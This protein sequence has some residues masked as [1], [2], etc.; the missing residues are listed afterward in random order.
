MILARSR[1]SGAGRRLGPNSR[2]G[3][4]TGRR[5]NGGDPVHVHVHVNV[6][7]NVDVNVHVNV[8]PAAGQ[9]SEP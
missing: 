3:M 2:V 4:P 9:A 7:V 5:V 6:H 1:A 8:L